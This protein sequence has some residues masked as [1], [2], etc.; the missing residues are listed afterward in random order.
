MFSSIRGYAQAITWI[1]L[2]TRKSGR[3]STLR[4]FIANRKS[5][6]D[7]QLK[8]LHKELEEVAVVERALEKVSADEE[9]PKSPR[10]G[11]KTNL[12]DMVLEV[13]QSAP[14]G[15]VEEAIREAISARY[16]VEVAGESLAS[17]LTRL[18]AE[19]ALTDN[20]FTWSLSP[21]KVEPKTA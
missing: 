2:H 6:I 12:K 21:A 14:N 7:L 18:C 8:A 15:M 16:G 3:M 4:E 17:M 9:A 13:L 19:Q 11:G 10:A 1:D 20:G 5:E